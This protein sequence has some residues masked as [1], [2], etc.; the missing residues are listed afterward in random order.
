[1]NRHDGKHFDLIAKLKDHAA[2]DYTQAHDLVTSQYV[3]PN[4]QYPIEYRL[5]I[6]EA[7]AKEQKRVFKTHVEL[8]V[9]LVHDS[10]RRKCPASCYAFDIAY[11]VQDLTEVIEKYV[12][13]WVGCIKTNRWL[14]VGEREIKAGD[15]AKE[16]P[17][18]AYHKETIHGKDYW[19]FSKVVRVSKFDRKL[20]VVISYDNEKREGDPKIFVTNALT[21]EARRVLTAYECRWSVETFYRDSKQELG[22]DGY[23]LRDEGGFR[24]HWHL[25]FAAYSC[26]LS[27]LQACGRRRWFTAKLLSIGEARRAI[28][29]DTVKSLIQWVRQK[30]AENW[31]TGEIYECLALA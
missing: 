23:E 19:V 12:K 9:E 27:E 20:R 1:L 21:W 16:L 17:D 26:L 13:N 14:T 25:V 8:A 24:R 7:V 22:L 31:D 6:P 5:F 10:E 11:T 29:Q 3:G 2:G 28:T 15:F 18:S 4:V 30:V